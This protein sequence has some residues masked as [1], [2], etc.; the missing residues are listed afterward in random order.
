[1]DGAFGRTQRM[2]DAINLAQKFAKFSDH[3]SPKVV[4]E[5]ND[6]Q[7]KLVKLQGNFVWHDHA[8]TDE[9]FLV[10]AGEM[11][12]EFRD[13]TVTLTKGEMVVITK[14]VEHRP[15]AESECQA[16]LIE[17]RGVV[18]TGETDSE[19]TAANDVWV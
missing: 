12:I 8:D 10:I 18:N 7:F 17:P 4:A 11:K 2:A 14:G 16:M 5:M 6:Y 13:R 9:V 3:W 19:F 15:H 1:M